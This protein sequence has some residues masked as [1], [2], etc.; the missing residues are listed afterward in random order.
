MTTAAA[1]MLALILVEALDPAAASG[2]QQVRAGAD[3]G[4]ITMPFIV[5]SNRDHENFVHPLSFYSRGGPLA[6]RSAATRGDQTIEYVY[7]TQRW[8]GYEWGNEHHQMG[9]V[10]IPPGSNKI[11]LGALNRA[12]GS[13]RYGTYRVV[14]LVAWKDGAGNTLGRVG[15]GPDRKS[16][17]ECDVNPQQATCEQ[18]DSYVV[19][20]QGSGGGGT[21]G[22]NP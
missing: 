8:T 18:H 7:L 3:P 5:A 9:S 2:W 1:P 17:L 6:T 4:T 20:G 13:L 19:L 10:V 21:V 11:R 12:N 22:G 16:D 15:M 14:L